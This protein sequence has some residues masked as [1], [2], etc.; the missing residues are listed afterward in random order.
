M[1]SMTARMPEVHAGPFPKLKV[2]KQSGPEIR[3]KVS[4]DPPC[5]G[6]SATQLSI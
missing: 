6:E 5:Q 1:A 3:L 4:A 2:R